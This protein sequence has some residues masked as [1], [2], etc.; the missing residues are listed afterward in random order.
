MTR[1]DEPSSDHTFN[2]GVALAG[3][4]GWKPVKAWTDP[5]RLFSL[6]LL[7]SVIPAKAGIQN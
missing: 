3:A 2:A 1:Y 7:R 4:A 5:E 6:H